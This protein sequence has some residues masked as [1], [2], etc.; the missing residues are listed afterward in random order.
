MKTR[1]SKVERGVD[2]GNC[3]SL[4]TIMYLCRANTVKVT[5][6]WIP[7]IEEVQSKKLMIRTSHPSKSCQKHWPDKLHWKGSTSYWKSWRRGQ[8]CQRW[9]W[10]TPSR[11]GSSTTSWKVFL[12]KNK[13]HQT[14]KT[15]T[16]CF[17]KINKT[18]WNKLGLSC[19]KLSTAWA[20]Y[21]LAS[22]LAILLSNSRL[23]PKD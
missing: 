21:P 5:I 11:T 20:S 7:D 14:T 18:N 23:S 1:V 12:A 19:A 22:S 4:V 13:I 8:C 10:W 3:L 16:H 15:K 2:R 17:I 6:D 9:L